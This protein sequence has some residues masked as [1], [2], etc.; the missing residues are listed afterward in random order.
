MMAAIC[1]K[2]LCFFIVILLLFS[3]ATVTA[4]P[5]TEQATEQATEPGEN[6][7]EEPG[8][9]PGEEPTEEPDKGVQPISITLIIGSAN[10]TVNGETRQIDE[11]GSA[12]FIQ[13]G[14]TLVPLR[15]VFEALS[16]NVGWD[17]GAITGT[18]GNT[19]IR[20]TVGST[21]AYRNG[22]RL[23]LDVAPMVVNDR[24]M[25][26]IRFIAES[27]GAS[28]SWTPE[29]QTIQI[30]QTP[31]FVEFSGERISLGDTAAR[32]QNMFGFA[33]RIDPSHYDFEWHV[34]H[35]DYSRFIM[36]GIK[37]GYVEALYT[38]SR[39]FMTNNASF[40]DVRRNVTNVRG[41]TVYFDEHYGNRAH[42]VMI[43][44]A[45]VE[46]RTQFDSAFFS[47]QER[48]NFDATNA[49]RVN[50]GRSVLTW[51][52]LAALTSRQHSQDM[53]NNDYFDHRALD[54][55]MP[56]HRF[57]RNGGRYQYIGE[58]LAGGYDLGVEAFDGLVNSDTHRDNMLD[59]RHR[60][61]GVGVVFKADSTYGTYL[62][63]LFFS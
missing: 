33:D 26:P 20:L 7:A 43:I 40:G 30:T 8:E 57:E 39:G 2:L 56:W 14:R 16:L 31:Q 12:P 59:R 52:D 47:T 60:Y 10:M 32:V 17:S 51:N 25:V 1:K 55:S 28:V 44:S 45:N 63:Q 38:N 19:E 3:P 21:I 46:R 35:G 9:E 53:A 11:E 58:N 5:V 37:N 62:G 24:T 27:I 36:V 13:G 6:P 42:A 48:Q 4:Q 18:R 50:H 49:F 23:L 15:A 61:L 41:I 29:T 34:F 22:R 54:G